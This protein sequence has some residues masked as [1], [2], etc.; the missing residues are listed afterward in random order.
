MVVYG[1]GYKRNFIKDDL[2]SR[3]LF[4]SIWWEYLI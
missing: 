4:Y 1:V 2:I 3:E